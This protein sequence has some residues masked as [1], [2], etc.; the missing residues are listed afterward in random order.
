MKTRLHPCRFQSGVSLIETLIYMAVLVVVLT[1][2]F[3]GYGRFSDQ[4]RR[5]QN[6]TMDIGQ[7]VDAGERW[8]EDVRRATGEIEADTEKGE[9]R[10]PQNSLE[11]VYRF[12]ENQVERKT[13][14]TFL[15]LLKNVKASSMQR[16]ERQHV[17]AWRWELELNT[18]G[19]NAKLQP[20]FQFEAV[21]PNRS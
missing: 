8:R 14:G 18:R 12:S 19:K 10:I 2:A 3:L 13:G 9:L 4:S 20:L 15:P 5:L 17:T 1:M 6:V 11:V 7:A 21:A 16:T